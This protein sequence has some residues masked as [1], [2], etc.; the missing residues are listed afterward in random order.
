[1]QLFTKSLYR[2]VDGDEDFDITTMIE[3]KYNLS[4]LLDSLSDFEIESESDSTPDI[5]SPILQDEIEIN[6]VASASMI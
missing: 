6:E 5:D 2:S 4:S 1:M 3:E